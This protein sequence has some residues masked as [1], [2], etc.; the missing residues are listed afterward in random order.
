[1]IVMAIF[2]Y[3]TYVFSGYVLY[4]VPNEINIYLAPLL[5]I[6][7]VF[8]IAQ[9]KKISDLAELYEMNVTPHNYYS[10]LASMI[11]AQFCAIIPNFRI[12]EIDIDDVPWKDELVNKLPEIS[13]GKLVLS[14]NPGWGIEINEEVL[15]A[16]QWP[17]R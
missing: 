15:R 17:K 4:L 3:E 13:D 9:S 6:T 12:M 14:K 11:S 1:M 5:A 2:F 10:H 16:H 8:L 7:A